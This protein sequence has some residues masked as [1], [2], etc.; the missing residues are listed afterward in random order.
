MLQIL[1]AVFWLLVIPFGCGVFLTKKMPREQ[2]SLGNIFLNGYLVM[3]ALF[4][5]VYLC[6]VLL[7][8]NDFNLLSIVFGITVVIF[9]LCSTWLG[10]DIV[11]PCVKCLKNKDALL[12]KTVFAVIVAAQLV[13]RLMQQIYDGDD[14]FYIAT[15]TASYASGTMNRIQPYTGFVIDGLD[16]RHAL[17][18]A[19]IWMAFLSKVTMI[20]PAIM[21]HSVLSLIMIVLHYLV[22]LGSGSVLFKEKKQEKYLFASLVGFFN[23]YGYVSIYT[24]QTFF[25]T[26]TWQGK[27]IFANLFLP[28]LLLL[29]LRIGE[30]KQKEKVS[31]LYYIWAAIILFGAVSMTTMGVLIA[32]V[33]FMFGIAFLAIYH[34]NPKMF[35]KALFACVPVG[36][37][38]LL[39]FIL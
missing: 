1:L 12:L 23:I 10:R 16:M 18:G 27:S 22:I 2:Q 7:K 39:Y 35:F 14:A 36:L 34:R 11:V 8:S 13:M 37:V 15:A 33:L 24:A 28:V 5:C 21:G 9:A 26:R 20:H 32:P 6:F 3:I 38:G 4:Q 30:I 29:L 19:P 31:N 17:A 25:L